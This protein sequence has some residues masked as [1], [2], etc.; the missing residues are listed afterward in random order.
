M[1][2]LLVAMAFLAFSSCISVGLYE[3]MAHGGIDCNPQPDGTIDSRCPPDP[4]Q[5]ESAPPDCSDA[6][7]STQPDQ[8]CFQ[9]L[10]S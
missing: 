3:P 9:P 1:K 7:H 5:I 2:R 6:M 10:K 4:P 8:R